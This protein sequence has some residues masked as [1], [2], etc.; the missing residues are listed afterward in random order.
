MML[1]HLG[2]HEAA[3]QVVAAIEGVLDEER[4]V[5]TPDLG[6]TGTTAG[7]GKAIAARIADGLPEGN[8]GG[9]VIRGRAARATNRDGATS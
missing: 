3:A 4:D 1:T 7:L 6:G 5:V 9:A 2:E 8:G